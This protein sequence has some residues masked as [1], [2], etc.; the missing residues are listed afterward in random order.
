MIL[1]SERVC[2]DSKD[3]ITVTNVKNNLEDDKF[4]ESVE[5][6]IKDKTIMLDH[7]K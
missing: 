4:W 6:M 5:V 3:E 2:W 7:D 1:L